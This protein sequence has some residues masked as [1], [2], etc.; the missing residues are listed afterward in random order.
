FVD[1]IGFLSKIGEPGDF[2]VPAL[3]YVRYWEALS[4][5]ESAIERIGED[6]KDIIAREAD[7]FSWMPMYSKVS[8][9]LPIQEIQGELKALKFGIEVVASGIVRLNFDPEVIEQVWV[10]AQRH[11]PGAD[12]LEVDME[13]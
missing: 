1:L 11:D 12:G 2:R 10:D 3:N 13:A 6:G 8:G 9:G 7:S 5:D 4:V